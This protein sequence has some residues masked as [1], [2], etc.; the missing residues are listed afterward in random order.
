MALCRQGQITQAMEELYSDDII[1]TEPEHAPVK[2]ARGKKNVFEKGRQFAA[3]I[4]ERHGG[5]I[6]DPVVGGRYFSMA[7]MLDATFRGQG[8][9]VFDEICV[10][11][12]KEGMIVRE[13]FFF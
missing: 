4:E 8:R 7:M 6:S 13:Q 3:L 10:Y 9:M 1:S 12:V 11:E 2:S 5:S